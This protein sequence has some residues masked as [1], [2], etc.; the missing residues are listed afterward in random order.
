MM[1]EYFEQALTRDTLIEVTTTGRKSGEIPHRR[2]TA[3]AP[4]PHRFDG[5]KEGGRM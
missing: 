2:L 1:E 4:D 5:D 3:L